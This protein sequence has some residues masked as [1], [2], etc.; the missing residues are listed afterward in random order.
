MSRKQNRPIPETELNRILKLLERASTCLDIPIN[1]S[2]VNLVDLMEPGED[3]VSLILQAASHAGMVM[4]PVSLVAHEI[5]DVLSEGMLVLSVFDGTEFW[6]LES[7]SG[8]NITANIFSETM[9]GR[10]L[11]E[12]E[13]DSELDTRKA[14]TFVLT[15][16]LACEAASSFSQHSGGHT[17][18]AAHNHH[19]S[20]ASRFL[21][22]LRLDQRDIW[23]V[24]LF[25]LVNGILGLASPL[26]VEALVNV[27]SWGTYLQ[28]LL[29]L[30]L[31]LLLCLG[32]A[33]ILNILQSFVVEIIQRRQFVRI[34]SDLAHR[35]PRANQEDLKGLYAREYANRIFDIMTIQKSVATLL[36]DGI[37]IVLATVLGMTLL[38][39]YHPFLLG[40]DLVLLL[41]MIAITWL[42]G[43]GGVDTAIDE[44]ITK[45][46]VAHWLQDVL[47]SPAAFKV[48]G[49]ES[50]AIEQA[51]RLT[52]QYVL[53]RQK[54]F[55]VVIR[56]FAFAIGLQAIASTAIL[57][58]GG[59]LVIRQQ[60]T[61]GQLVASELIVTVV[62]GAFSKAG[63][64]FEK[65]YDLMAS[66]DKVGHLLDIS[67]DQRR[68]IGEVK[69]APA[70]IQWSNLTLA[71]TPISA[72]HIAAG[73]HVAVTG[74]SVSARNQLLKAISGLVL[75]EHGRIE[76]NGTDAKQ[77]A[78]SGR[79][80]VAYAGPVEFI[81]STLLTNVSLARTSVGLSHVRE[82]IHQVGL[83][84]A[85]A[86][87]PHG[88][89]SV[90]QSDGQP[91]SI[92]QQAQ[93]MIARAIVGNPKLL[94]IDGLLDLLPVEL[95]RH[96]WMNLSH[97]DNPWTLIVG[98]CD[99][100]LV[101]SCSDVIE[102]SQ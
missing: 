56:Q 80:I 33:G 54:Q 6:L 79:S 2:A 55:R 16:E 47:S 44:S 32:L 69:D 82:A 76:I 83:T 49:G 93:L 57:G 52:T 58:L 85:I 11:T 9:V 89:D 91:L 50:L 26:A 18:A 3:L 14:Q 81:H 12:V 53:A 8:K 29:V 74:I 51:N 95:R 62:V 34:V 97:V 68:A 86:N 61:L 60:L 101:G 27:V 48:N 100:Q 4:R 15:R 39:F 92:A 46:R 90:L 99:S 64:L 70:E 84:E 41:S 94:I 66:I 102:L 40:F 10:N 7:I 59:W 72:T 43:R 75:P 19:H 13:L 88:L 71:G 5:C 25:A 77:V 37:S 96:I 22:M 30:G 36:L 28:P 87:L 38:A 65:F 23:T 45:Y 24:V 21:T 78:F 63:K 20:P 73:R 31:V 1:R 42:L 98:T 35:F 17:S 67:V